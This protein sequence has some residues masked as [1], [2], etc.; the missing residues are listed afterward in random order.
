MYSR[1]LWNQLK[2]ETFVHGS[3]WGNPDLG[4]APISESNPPDIPG[5]PDGPISG[6]ARTE[7]TFTSSTSDPDGDHVYY[8]FN[9]GDGTNSGWLGPYVSGEECN[10]TH[11]WDEQ[12]NYEIK[13]KAKDEYGAESDWSDPLPVS[14]PKTYENPLWALLEKLFDWLLHNIF[15]IE[16]I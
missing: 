5:R 6:K 8:L 2:Y 15:G 14:M 12:G 13:V 9:W 11:V 16:I 1:G 10:A 4:I 3:L 7:Y